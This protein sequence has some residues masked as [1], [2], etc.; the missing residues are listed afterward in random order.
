MRESVCV[1]RV[2]FSLERPARLNS[3]SGRGKDKLS[4]IQD[5][6]EI[7]SRQLMYDAIVLE[8]VE[9]HR[10][11]IYTEKHGNLIPT[12]VPL[13]TAELVGSIESSHPAVSEQMKTTLDRWGFNVQADEGEPARETLSERLIR[14][15]FPFAADIFLRL[16]LELGEDESQIYGGKFW[17]A[18]DLRTLLTEGFG[19]Y[20]KDL[21]KLVLSSPPLLSN[22]MSMF[23]PYLSP[24]QIIRAFRY[25]VEKG[26]K[27]IPG[28]TPEI[29]E[30]VMVSVVHPTARFN[31]AI[32]KDHW[33]EDMYF[34]DGN[35]ILRSHDGKP[36]VCETKING[37]SE[38]NRHTLAHYAQSESARTS[39]D[40]HW[41]EPLNG[42]QKDGY[43]IKLLST[44]S[45]LLAT[46][47]KMSVCVGRLS[48]W[49]EVADGVTILVRLDG[50][51]GMAALIDFQREESGW[52]LQEAKGLSNSAPPA[53]ID[54]PALT[55]LVNEAYFDHTSSCV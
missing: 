50:P 49:N 51:D 6:S 4:R 3:E 10:V 42:H 20:R 15:Q 35:F 22:W 43:T 24:D 40:L 7:I 13:G 17:T 48:Y 8:L 12:T 54:L 55:R 23:A 30:D 25:M 14:A 33:D 41:M 29:V 28:M 47:K 38:I 45:D 18:P 16:G 36:V 32:N 2:R 34:Y 27:T 21:A 9:P 26:N 19:F 5:L 11:A 31:L 1:E 53:D 39:V 44:I 37:W 46:G 52:R